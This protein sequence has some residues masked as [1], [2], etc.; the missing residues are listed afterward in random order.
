MFTTAF[1][2]AARRPIHMV[3]TV[4]QCTS[5]VERLLSSGKSS[6]AVDCEGPLLGRFGRLSLV[7]LATD[8]DVFLVDV[9]VGGPKVVQ[10]L[11]PLLESREVTKVFHDC[12]EDAA[13]LLHQ[14][15]A[16]LTNVFDTQ[17]AHSLW[18][19]RQ[20]W[21]LYQASLPEV[22]RTF[23]L[24]TYRAHRW[25]ELERKPINPS[26][27]QDRPLAPHAARYAIEGV[28]HLLPL[29]KTICRALGDPGGDLVIQRSSQYVQYSHLNAA[30]LASP[31]LSGLRPGAPLCAML[32]A[33]RPDAAFFKLNHSSLTG[34]VLEHED[35]RDFQDLQ[36]GDVASCRVKSLSECQQFVHLQREG[37]GELMFDLRKREMRRLPSKAD[38][39]RAYPDRQSTMYG[40]GRAGPGAPPLV[41]E[42]A[43]F[44]EE[45][46]EVIHKVGKRGAVKVRNTSI[47]AP[48]QASV[49]PWQEA[50]PRERR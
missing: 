47:K 10:P 37:H 13:L 24:S 44:R 25:D 20:G 39:D 2:R 7:Q 40:F 46:S 48:R 50:M 41:S 23:M 9:T 14:H 35:L 16:G 36:P 33:R 43:S 38:V 15:E 1:R 27:W 30:E 42:K 22:L 49:E 45:K 8:D 11:V 28:A 32:A 17:V 34:R 19:E 29:Q 26:R 4:D 18:L 6:V 5:V 3:T 21:E 12:R 31:D